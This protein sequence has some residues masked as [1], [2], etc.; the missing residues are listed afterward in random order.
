MQTRT[1]LLIAALLPLTGCGGVVSLHPLAIPNG[2][3]TVF[4]PALM[5]EWESVD[6]ESRNTTSIYAVD[7]GESG[8]RVILTTGKDRI[9]GTMHLLRLGDRYLLDV[10][11]PGQAAPPPVHLFLRLRLEKDSA[12]LS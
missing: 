10:L 7:R 1:A 3:E 4:D 11:C 12:W 5:G 6:A 8:Y 9:E 2:K